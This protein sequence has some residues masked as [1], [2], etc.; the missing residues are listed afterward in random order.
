MAALFPRARRAALAL[1]LLA[2]LPQAAQAR[3]LADDVLAELNFA[4]AQPASSRA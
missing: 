1:V 2:A 4:R 3:S